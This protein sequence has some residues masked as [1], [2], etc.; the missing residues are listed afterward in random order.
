MAGAHTAR[1]R[2]LYKRLLRLHGRLPSDLRLLGD[3]YVKDE[4]RKNKVAGASEA[5]RF[6]EEWQV[7]VEEA[8]GVTASQIEMAGMRESELLSLW[9]ELQ[10][11]E[12]KLISQLQEVEEI[13][14]TVQVTCF[15]LEK[16]K[17]QL[18]IAEMR[19][20]TDSM[21]NV[22]DVWYMLP[23]ADFPLIEEETFGPSPT[24]SGVVGRVSC[25]QC[26]A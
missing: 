18:P 6:L 9:R 16:I 2:A 3:Q 25:V 23:F 12:K 20:N 7:G 21:D 24:E 13:A 26:G 10:G 19:K 8:V 11:P 15:R 17:Q 1:V 4:F 5:T 22:L 14:G